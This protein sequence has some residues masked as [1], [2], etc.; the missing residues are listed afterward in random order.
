[1]HPVVPLRLWH[2]AFRHWLL[3]TGIGFGLTYCYGMYVV[4]D[5][6]SLHQIS[7]SM[8]TIAS[9][10]TL[11][12]AVLGLLGLWW[13]RVRLL[14]GW[15]ART[16]HPRPAAGAGLLLTYLVG[17]GLVYNLAD[18]AHSSSWTIP[19]LLPVWC[20]ASL[21]ALYWVPL[22]TKEYE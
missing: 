8:L 10:V 13:V 15:A 7:S 16:P 3:T 21:L 20:A 22:P 4:R 1:M 17:F 5:D 6:T 11:V 12:G 2:L 14:L 18:I 19:L 9:L